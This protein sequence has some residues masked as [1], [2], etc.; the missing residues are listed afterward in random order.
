[1]TSFGI[2]QY[3]PHEQVFGRS[4]HIDAGRVLYVIAFESA[5]GNHLST[6]AHVADIGPYHI[7]LIKIIVDQRVYLGVGRRQVY[8]EHDKE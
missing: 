6:L 2:L 3:G 4:R 8:R 1:M 7:V 5:V